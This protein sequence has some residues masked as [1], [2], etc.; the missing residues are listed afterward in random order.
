MMDM[1]MDCI[2][3]LENN[4]FKLLVKNKIYNT[5]NIINAG[6]YDIE[7]ISTNFIKICSN[8]FF[9]NNFSKSQWIKFNEKDYK[10]MNSSENPEY[11][12]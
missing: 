3:L 12:L 5:M 2:G 11:F 1:K 8:Q 10:I 6:L 7:D 9:E 4:K